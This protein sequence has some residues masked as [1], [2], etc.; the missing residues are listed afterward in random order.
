M[1]DIFKGSTSHSEYVVLVDSTTGLPKTGIADTSVTGSYTRARAAR[2]AISMSALGAAD[3][4][5]SSGGWFE[6][7]SANTP[8]LYRIDVPDAAF[9]T[10][11]DQVYVT[12]KATGCKTETKEF[13]LT[14][15]NGQVAS[16][17]NAV[18]GAAGG[19][20][21]AGTNAATSA[22]ITG[23]ITGNLSGSVGSVSG[24]VGSVTGAVGSVASGGITAASF[25]AGALDAVWSVA[26]RLLTAGT[27]IVL[28]KGTGVT[29]LNDLDAA[30]VRTAVGLATANLDTQ[31]AAVQADMDDIQTRLPAALVSGRMDASAGAIAA[32]AI[33]AASMA[34]DASAEIADAVWDEALSGH[35]ISGSTGAGLSAASAAGDPW[36][37]A[38]P[39]AYGAG[40]AG[41]IVGDNLNATISSRAATGAAM[42]L[43]AGERTSVADAL[44]NR[45]MSAVTVTNSRSPINSLRF[46][47][48]KWTAL[49]GTLTV[50]AEDDTTVAFSAT[51]ATSS[52]ADPVIGSDPS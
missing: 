27:N 17:P 47:R 9:A 36:G 21:I 32:N 6:V 49:F 3:S 48:N 34:A 50:Y 16:I 33:T 40:T 37:T 23:N 1:R 45:D 24:A 29:G 52:S 7:D 11:V 41:K 28:A 18:A 15:W 30:G 39:G 46:L 2:A 25:A 38:L 12:I 19:V 26:T 42:T 10:G 31:I 35:A 51:L 14:D 5:Y 43:T 22:S 13:R 8:G 20:F 44:L 4:A